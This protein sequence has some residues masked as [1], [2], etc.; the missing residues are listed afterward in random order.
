MYHKGQVCFYKPIICQE[1]SC[2]ECGIYLQRIG[3]L[4]LKDLEKKPIREGNNVWY[5]ENQYPRLN[6]TSESNRRG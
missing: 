3:K 5:I 6:K 2:N 4:D 1:G